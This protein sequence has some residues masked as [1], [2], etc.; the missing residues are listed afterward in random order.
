MGIYQLAALSGDGEDFA[1][2]ADVRMEL[3]RL[4][5]L[6]DRPAIV[7]QPGDPVPGGE[8]VL[9]PDDPVPPNPHL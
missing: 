6:A 8:R 4:R 9:R 5:V 7:L 2:V 1:S 3:T